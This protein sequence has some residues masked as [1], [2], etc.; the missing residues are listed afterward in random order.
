MSAQVATVSASMIANVFTLLR[1]QQRALVR[2]SKANPGMTMLALTAVLYYW[3]GLMR[4]KKGPPRG[5]A[6][7]HIKSNLRMLD[8]AYRYIKARIE[9]DELKFV[10][11]LSKQGLTLTS[12]IIGHCMILVF[13]PSSVQHILVKNF[14]N[15]PKGPEY[16]RA[17]FPFMGTGIF[18]ADGSAWKNQRALARPHFQ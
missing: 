2:R 9:G 7:P 14:E 5:M 11:S 10:Q 12:Q 6:I 15:Y 17:F 1:Q 18:N 16:H 4:A 13:E 3:L 8:V